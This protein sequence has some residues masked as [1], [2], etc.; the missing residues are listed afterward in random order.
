MLFKEYPLR[1]TIQKHASFLIRST[2]VLHSINKDWLGMAEAFK[3]CR[4]AIISLV[5]AAA[6]FKEH[7]KQKHVS[8]IHYCTNIYAATAT[9]FILYEF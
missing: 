5:V 4:L 9:T 2:L 6:S 1:I 8:I 7:F 3:L